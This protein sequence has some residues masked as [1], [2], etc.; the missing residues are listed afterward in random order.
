MSTR[1]LLRLLLQIRH[2]RNRLI[3]AA[4]GRRRTLPSG[5]VVVFRPCVLERA[6]LGIEYLGLRWRV[7]GQWVDADPTWARVGLHQL[8][9]GVSVGAKRP[10]A[11]DAP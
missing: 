10:M 4:T 9:Q 5:T 1:A 2:I 11:A 8:H 7:V 6:D 3:R